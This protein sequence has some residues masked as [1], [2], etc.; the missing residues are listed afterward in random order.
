MASKKVAVDNDL[1]KEIC[2]VHSSTKRDELG[3]DSGATP[4]MVTPSPVPSVQKRV[5][6]TIPENNL[7]DAMFYYVSIF[8]N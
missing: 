5:S 3:A 2:R 7:K 1:V 8:G 6:P 4:R